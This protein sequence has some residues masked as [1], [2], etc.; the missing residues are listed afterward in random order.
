MVRPFKL[1][2]DY[3]ISK[4]IFIAQKRSAT[5]VTP[6]LLVTPEIPMLNLVEDSTLLS[7]FDNELETVS[8]SDTPSWLSGYCHRT[9]SVGQFS[10]AL[11][12]ESIAFLE[13]KQGTPRPAIRIEAS[14]CP[15]S[16]GHQVTACTHKHVTSVHSPL[17]N[18][19]VSLARFRL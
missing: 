7:T 11:L 8:S 17:P 15:S 14:S 4:P 19:E 2:L 5:G 16:K 18:P 9:P 12:T 1:Q 3:L 13:L 6:R 10:P